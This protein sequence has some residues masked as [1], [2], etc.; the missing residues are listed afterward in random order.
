MLWRHRGEDI[1]YP[2]EL[3]LEEA[4]FGT[5]RT[6]ALEKW[7]SCQECNGKGYNP[8]TAFKTCAKCGG[9][10]KIRESHRT[11]FGVFARVVPCAVCE[12]SGRIPEIPCKSCMGSGRKKATTSL[13][14]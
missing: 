8:N 13:T 10:G 11:M 5:N 7:L 14:V 12:G 1:I 4:V 9:Q 3:T 6:I 2:V